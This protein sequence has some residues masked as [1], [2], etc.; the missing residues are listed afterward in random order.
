M[1]KLAL[2]LGGSILL[3]GVSFGAGWQVQAWRH[4]AAETKQLVRVVKQIEYRDRETV[5]IAA[6]HA[7]TRTEI[8]WRTRTLIEKVPEYVT[9]QA[10]AACPVPVGFVRLHDAAAAGVAREFGATGGP[11]D[12]PSGVALSAV[13]ETV[14]ANYGT[15]DDTRNTLLALQ[16]W[17]RSRQAAEALK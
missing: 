14:V 10:D 11:D 15:C 8:Q 16:A 17:E 1:G 9:V 7:A 4:G 12:R 13:A 6:A 3:A 5:K 2:F